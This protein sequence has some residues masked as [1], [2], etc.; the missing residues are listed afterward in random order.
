MTDQNNTDL[1]ADRD[2]WRA[3]AMRY[4]TGLVEL[5]ASIRELRA[6]L[7]ASQEVLDRACEWADWRKLWQTITKKARRFAQAIRRRMR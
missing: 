3:E 2:H 4:K 5:H 7:D 6:A 1:Q